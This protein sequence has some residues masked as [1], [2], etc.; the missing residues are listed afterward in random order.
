M[1]ESCVLYNND[2]TNFLNN[3][4]KKSKINDISDSKYSI[5]VSDEP[6]K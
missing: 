3:D 2:V 4:L 5:S 6:I 1:K